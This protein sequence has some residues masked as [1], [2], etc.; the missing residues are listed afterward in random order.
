[1]IY[2]AP[3]SA[4]PEPPRPPLTGW[5]LAV[6][7]LGSIVVDILIRTG[8]LY[9]ALGLISLRL[10]ADVRWGLE[11]LDCMVITVVL[12]FMTRPWGYKNPGQSP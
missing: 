11:L 12:C 10:G 4:M 9:S 7:W 2:F 1:M 6:S 3:E 8:L 5:R